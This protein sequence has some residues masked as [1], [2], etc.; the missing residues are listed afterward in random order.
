[1][2]QIKMM[3]NLNQ[4]LS[5]MVQEGFSMNLTLFLDKYILQ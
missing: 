3:C 1:M 5:P 4:I 2:S